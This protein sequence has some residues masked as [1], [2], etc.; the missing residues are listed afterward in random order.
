MGSCLLRPLLLWLFL[1]ENLVKFC[2]VVRALKRLREISLL[3]A[4]RVPDVP[5]MR[6]RYTEDA[7]LLYRV[8][9]S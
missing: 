8:G 5:N 6:S 7:F 4:F 9:C 3:S 1:L 2:Y